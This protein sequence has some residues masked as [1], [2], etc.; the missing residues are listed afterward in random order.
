VPSVRAKA[1]PLSKS[2]FSAA[3]GRSGAPTYYRQLPFSSIVELALRWVPDARIRGLA[4]GRPAHEKAIRPGGK[5][6]VY[7]ICGSRSIVT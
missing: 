1:A 7:L 6:A 5:V 2:R 3:A 4:P